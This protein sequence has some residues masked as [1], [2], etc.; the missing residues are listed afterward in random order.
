ML[1]VDDLFK[2]RHFDREII[3]LC[4]RWY[5]RYKLSFRDLVEMMAERGLSLAPTTIMRWVQRYIP[6]FERRWNCYARQVGGSW[7]VDETYVKIKGIHPAKAADF[8]QGRFATQPAEE[9][10]F[11][12]DK[13]DARSEKAPEG[14]ET[15]SLSRIASLALAGFL[16][17]AVATPCGAI[18]GGAIDSGD[19]FADVVRI[20]AG[21][22]VCSGVLLEPRV[23]ITLAS[24]FR[25][26]KTGVVRHVGRDGVRE[27]RIVRVVTA[28]SDDRLAELQKSA[29][30]FVVEENL[31]RRGPLVLN[32]NDQMMYYSIGAWAQANA[33][34]VELAEDLPLARSFASLPPA[35][36][37][38]PALRDRFDHVGFMA[39]EALVVGF[40][41]TAPC[42]EGKG[43]STMQRSFGPA[44]V[45][46]GS[47]ADCNYKNA[48]YICG[49]RLTVVGREDGPKSLFTAGDAG[50]ALVLK[51]STGEYVLAGLVSQQL[52]RSYADGDHKRM[53]FSPLVYALLTSPFQGLE[54]QLG[55]ELSYPKFDVTGPAP[56]VA[57]TP[58]RD[59]GPDI[60]GALENREAGATGVGLAFDDDV[61]LDFRR[62]IVES[63]SWLYEQDDLA[64]FGKLFLSLGIDTEGPMRGRDLVAWLLRH[65]RIVAGSSCFWS[66][67]HVRVSW[68]PQ[69]SRPRLAEESRAPCRPTADPHVSGESSPSY[70]NDFGP[71]PRERKVEG[72]VVGDRVVIAHERLRSYP[73]VVLHDM[74]GSADPAMRMAYVLGLLFHE[75]HHFTTPSF[76]ID[77]PRETANYGK[78]LG[79]RSMHGVARA[80]DAGLGGAYTVSGLF[81]RLVRQKKCRRSCPYNL[82]AALVDQESDYL[83]RVSVRLSKPVVQDGARVDRVPPQIFFRARKERL[84]ALER[85]CARL[86]FPLEKCENSSSK[87]RYSLRE[88]ERLLARLLSDLE[89]GLSPDDEKSW[90]LLTRYGPTKAP[91]AAEAGRWLARAREARATGYNVP[92]KWAVPCREL[93]GGCPPV[94]HAALEKEV[95][96][97]TAPDEGREEATARDEDP[98]VDEAPRPAVKAARPPARAPERLRPTYSIRRDVSLGVQNMRSGPGQGHSLVVGV[99]AGA[100]G[101]ALGACAPADD[102]VSRHP[103]CR[104]DWRGH[105]GWISKCCLVPE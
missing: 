24:C 22:N 85:E 71:S 74:S 86:G 68:L 105:S 65:L 43:C 28:V 97:R 38:E 61:P 21:E 41:P 84:E 44:T 31:I 64:D 81:Q 104:A 48:A 95:L 59:D 23:A 69:L 62:D 78:L 101:V 39:V 94:A 93:A 70:T 12:F 58:R 91:D 80:C 15:M 92:L 82:E 27:A 14:A 47:G 34:L 88:N 3:I 19:L 16:A 67:N 102:G 26:G 90:K 98:R 73:G 2:G 75:T 66:D 60:V 45:V 49:D 56:K 103:W 20:E 18:T 4:V 50:G 87:R 51:A 13:A 5:L 32:D 100:G 1:G 89:A 57:P 72:F 36:P 25:D 8:R 42:V 37:V 83:G 6:E 54:R 35:S 40:G 11:G 79:F 55:R 77:C 63:L 9:R 96:A 7:R 10:A 29:E 52:M 17:V 53:M 76:H 46:P 33:A 30:K 99:P